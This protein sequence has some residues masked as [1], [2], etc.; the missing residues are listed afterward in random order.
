M[1]LAYAVG[2]QRFRPWGSGMD[3]ALCTSHRAGVTCCHFIFSYSNKRVY[4]FVLY[5]A[6]RFVNINGGVKS[7]VLLSLMGVVCKWISEKS[8]V[9][10]WDLG[11]GIWDLENDDDGKNK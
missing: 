8:V 3:L 7:E 11:F 5:L 1:G 10:I 4:V 6:F 9:G 2:G